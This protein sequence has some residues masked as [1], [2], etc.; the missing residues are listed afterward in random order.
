[1]I[2]SQH[3]ELFVRIG[4]LLDACGEG[5]GRFEVEKT[6]NFL[7]EYVISHF[8]AEETHM[9]KTGYP[10]YPEHKKQHTEFM[11][12]F[13]KLKKQFES[14]GPGLTI[15]LAANHLLVDWLKNHIRKV[16]KALGEYLKASA[17]GS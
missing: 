17:A 6:I 15:V 1:M 12:S 9:I 8:K 13:D 7:E 11:E 16:D 3:Q 4:N 5:K 2:D 14:Q 10:A